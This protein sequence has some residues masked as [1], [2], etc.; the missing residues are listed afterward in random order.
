M[1]GGLF[2]DHMY[3]KLNGEFRILRVYGANARQWVVMR[4]KTCGIPGHTRRYYEGHAGSEP[5]E[6]RPASAKRAG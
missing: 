6:M 3:E 1:I 5:R 2:V 4:S